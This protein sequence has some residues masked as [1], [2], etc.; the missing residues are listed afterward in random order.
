ML[1]IIVNFIAHVIS[2]DTSFHSCLL[3]AANANR[4][5]LNQI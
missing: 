1:K 4:I 5:S 3:A 2:K